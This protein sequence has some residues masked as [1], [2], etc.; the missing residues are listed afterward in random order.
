MSTSRPSQPPSGHPEW[1]RGMA[2]VGSVAAVALV[3][4]G[5]VMLATSKHGG[6]I[7]FTVGV[8]GLVLYGA[9]IPLSRRRHSR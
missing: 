5:A 4:L 8:I 2:I 7:V 9:M 1:V 3:I 6:P